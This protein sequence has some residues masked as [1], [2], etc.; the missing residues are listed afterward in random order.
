MN[1]M[2]NMSSSMTGKWLGPCK[3]GQKHGSMTTSGMPGMS[4]GGEF[5]MDAETMNRMRQMQAQYGR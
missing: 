2:Q 3:P 1:G 5:K 4:P